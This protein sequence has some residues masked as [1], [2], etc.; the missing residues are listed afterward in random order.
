[1]KGNH[2]IPSEIIGAGQTCNIGS[3]I[4][5]SETAFTVGV[6]LRQGLKRGAGKLAPLYKVARGKALQTQIGGRIG[7]TAATARVG[8][9]HPDDVAPRFNLCRGNCVL[10]TV[11]RSVSGSNLNAVPIGHIA[12][13]YLTKQ[14]T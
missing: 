10:A 6:L 4:V 7:Q 11:V 3:L 1:M 9:A 2:S 8:D 13:V 12:V 14:K 5:N